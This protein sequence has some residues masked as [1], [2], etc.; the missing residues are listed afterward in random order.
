MSSCVPAPPQGLDDDC[1]G[2][3]EDCDGSFDEQAPSGVTSCGL[4]VC[5]STGS[6]RCVDGVWENS[7][8]PRQA[9][10]ADVSC[11]GADQDCDGRLMSFSLE[12]LDVVRGF[13]KPK[14]V[15]RQRYSG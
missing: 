10:G 15:W 7:C 4:G 2:V 14:G 11:D 9:F 6:R 3:D 12:P 1:N 5:E 13:I 8:V